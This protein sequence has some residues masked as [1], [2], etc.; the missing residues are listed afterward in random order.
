[1][2]KVGIG[3]GGFVA[4]EAFDVDAMDFFS[5][6]TTAGGSLSSTE[7]SA[8]NQL[9]KDLKTAGLW[10]KIHALYPIV[11]ASAAACAQNLKSSLFTGSF[12]AGWAFASTGITGNGVSTF[13]DTFFNPAVD[14]LNFNNGASIYSRTNISDSSYDYG[15]TRTGGVGHNVYL[16]YSGV[17][18][19][20]H[21]Q[22][23]FAQRPSMVPSGDTSS[24]FYTGVTSASND[25]RMYRNGSLIASD[26]QTSTTTLAQLNDTLPLGAQKNDLTYNNFSQRQYALFALHQSLTAGE[27]TSFNTANSTFQ[28]TLSR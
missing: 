14:F 10:N 16:N 7:K 13:M 20:W 21:L 2:I 6:V 18:M 28:T 3:I 11:G 15:I 9:V 19:R 27:V 25:R 22:C 24:G 8:T 26:T 17:G 5:R 23:T 1:M 12:S 4:P